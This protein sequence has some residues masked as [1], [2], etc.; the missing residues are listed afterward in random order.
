MHGYSALGEQSNS[1]YD[2]QLEKKE[3]G[4]AQ[5]KKDL[6]GFRSMYFYKNIGV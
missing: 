5:V 2:G 4:Q 1:R 6:E 3:F